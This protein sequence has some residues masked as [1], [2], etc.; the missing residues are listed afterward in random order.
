[1]FLNSFIWQFNVL[2]MQIQCYFKN[3]YN[4]IFPLLPSFR[5]LTSKCPMGRFVA[6]RFICK[7]KGRDV[8]LKK[9]L[10]QEIKLWNTID[11]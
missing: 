2:S 3:A 5:T 1:M 4:I 6:L 10:N 7:G 8:H 11:D 9:D